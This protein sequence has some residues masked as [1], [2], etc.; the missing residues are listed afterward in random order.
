MAKKLETILKIGQVT[1]E[2]VLKCTGK[3]WAEWVAILDRVGARGYSHQEIV[4]YLKT[5]HKLGPWWQQGV[6]L[7]YELHIGRRIDGQNQKGQYSVTSTRSVAL[8]A[9]AAWKKLASKEGVALWLKPLTPF[10]L[11]KGAVFEVSGGIH[12]EVRTLA[13]GR[14]ARFSWREGDEGKASYLTL[15][16]VGKPGNRSIVALSHDGLRTERDKERLRARWKAGLASIFQ[17]VDSGS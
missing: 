15:L 2:S 16:V 10:S 6:C 8:P 4:A 14:R 3:G 17:S 7:G 1:N 9:A 5:R 12:G 13:P 11:A